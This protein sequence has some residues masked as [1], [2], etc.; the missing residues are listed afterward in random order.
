[1]EAERKMAVL[2]R[3]KREAKYFWPSA[4]R[5]LMENYPA[6]LATIKEM[7]ANIDRLLKP[8]QV[9]DDIFSEQLKLVS[10]ELQ[11]LRGSSGNVSDVFI[12]YLNNMFD[13]KYNKL[14]ELI[15]NR[16]TV[17]NY[18]ETKIHRPV[19]VEEFK[20]AIIPEKHLE[21]FKPLYEPY[22]DVIPVKTKSEKAKYDDELIE[23]LRKANLLSQRNKLSNIASYS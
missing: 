2:D 1:M 16:P 17:T 7:R 18:F 21:Q 4:A 10:D 19:K 13:P 5:D 14:N 11:Q 3:A 8:R 6:Q 23:M 9:K 15:R 20:K 12:D 22:M